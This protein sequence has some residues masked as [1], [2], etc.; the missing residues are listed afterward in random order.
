MSFFLQAEEIVAKG[1]EMSSKEWRTIL[2]TYEE[3]LNGDIEFNSTCA[4]TSLGL[5]CSIVGASCTSKFNKA[6][7]L[8]V[9][10]ERVGGAYWVV[11]RELIRHYLLPL[12]M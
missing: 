3:S 1:R 4:I 9:S 5:A 8:L 2:N 6:F 12:M 10:W 7:C 11:Q